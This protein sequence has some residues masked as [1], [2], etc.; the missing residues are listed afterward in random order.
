MKL[1]KKEDVQM[2]D[3][4]RLRRAGSRVRSWQRWGLYFIAFGFVTA[5]ITWERIFGYILGLPPGSVEIN[6][7]WMWALIM[8]GGYRTE[9]SHA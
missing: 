5:F 2:D 3:S 4:T 6:T 8:K 7:F 9:I 1:S